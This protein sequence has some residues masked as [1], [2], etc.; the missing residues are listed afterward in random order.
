MILWF[1]KWDSTTDYP[2]FWLK[3]S[4]RDGL[5]FKKYYFKILSKSVESTN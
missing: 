1:M 4:L 2:K 5:K 3:S